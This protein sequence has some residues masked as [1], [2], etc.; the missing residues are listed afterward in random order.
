M[1][2][3]SENQ[4]L[5]EAHT[6]P[7]TA[8]PDPARA[9]KIGTVKAETEAAMND[10]AVMLT[11]DAE[12]EQQSLMLDEIDE[13][14]SLFSGPV[15][16]VA[17]IINE[18]RQRGRGRPKGSENKANAEFRNVLMRMGFRH[19]GLNLAAL[20]NANPK[21]LA[22]ELA[23]DQIEALKLIMKANEQ[24]LPY[25][26]SA[27]PAKVEVEDRRLGVMVIGTMAT[28]TGTETRTIDLTQ[29]DRPE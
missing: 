25:F 5:F 19:P 15:K 10:L 11:G 14:Q 3:H 29:V 16:H 21:E 7:A 24:L 6:P 28:S 26:E 27:R 13:Q 22:T 9:A 8:A 20:A 23:C 12:P 17:A 4:G 2:D 1:A 18:S